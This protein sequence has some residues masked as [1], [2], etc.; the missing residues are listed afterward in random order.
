MITLRGP[1]KKSKTNG[2]GN[3]AAILANAHAEQRVDAPRPEELIA[4]GAYFLAEQHGFAPGNEMLD[5]FRDG[6]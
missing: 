6:R 4:V 2:S 1:V 3:K 5:W